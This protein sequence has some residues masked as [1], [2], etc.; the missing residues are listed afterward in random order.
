MSSWA[1]LT[2]RAYL[3]PGET[4]L[5]NG[6]TGASGRLAVKI[7]RHLG[8]AKVIA[9]GRNAAVLDALGADVTIPLTDDGDDLE[10][11]FKAQFADRVDVVL[12]YLWGTS[13]E[14]LLIAGAKSGPEGVPIRFVQIGTASGAEISL[15]GAAL[16][17]SSI[18]IKGSG[19][20]SVSLAGLLESIAGVFAAARAADLTLPIRS[21]PLA[22]VEQ[23]WSLD[24]EKRTVFTF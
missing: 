14:R 21:V 6:A 12:D 1:A 22:E 10:R 8:A 5:I 19:I 17:S 4:V 13:A 11:Q 20:G 2:H 18:E 3:K 24:D 7:A 16:R 23:A 15:P 9:T